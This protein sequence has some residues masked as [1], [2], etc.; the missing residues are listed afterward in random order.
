MCRRIYTPLNPAP[1]HYIHF[2]RMYLCHSRPR[3]PLPARSDRRR[4][5][6][7][8]NLALLRGEPR[9]PFD[10]A[11]PSAR[12]PWPHPTTVSRRARRRNASKR[13][14]ASPQT[15]AA[16]LSSACLQSAVI[17]IS[18]LPSIRYLSSFLLLLPASPRRSL[19]LGGRSV[20]RS[21]GAVSAIFGSFSRAVIFPPRRCL[22]LSLS[23][24]P[25]Q[26]ASLSLC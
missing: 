18:P 7:T 10:A 3:P 11:V 1:G 2:S 12:A 19:G 20:T 23:S 15:S 25:P 26:P 16:P 17:V 14:S 9:R 21:V 13:L 22:Y 24:S 4:C 8:P 6:A 5:H